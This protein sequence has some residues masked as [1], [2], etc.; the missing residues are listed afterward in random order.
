MANTFKLSSNAGLTTSLVDQYTV[1][2]STTSIIVGMSVANT[3]ANSITV[4][5]KI[6]SDTGNNENAY[7]IKGGPVP[8][9]GTL[10][11]MSGNKLVLQTTDKIQALASTTGVADLLI[12]YM[13]I[14]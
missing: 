2:S 3:S 1:P 6:V 14:T 12:S 9:G 13:E 4:D 11:I 8:S 10:E 5:I 7:L